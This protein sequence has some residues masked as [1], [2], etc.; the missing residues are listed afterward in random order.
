MMGTSSRLRR[1]QDRCNSRDAYVTQ[2]ILTHENYD[3]VGGT[4]VFPTAEIHCQ[5][6][7]LEVFA[8]DTMGMVLKGELR[9]FEKFKE[10]QLGNQVVQLHH[11]GPS[12]GVANTIVYLP[13][14]KIIYSADIYDGTDTL[15]PD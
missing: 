4:E 7:C 12:K 3:H 2:I 13:K 5:V 15:V 10:I 11:Y 1:D 8:L 9:T 14:E 6:L